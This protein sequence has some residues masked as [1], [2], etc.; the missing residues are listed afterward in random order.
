MLRPPHGGDIEIDACPLQPFFG[1]GLHVAVLQP[2]LG[3]QRLQALEVLIDRPRTDGTAA[4]QR[5]PRPAETGQKRPKHQYRGPHGLDQ[6]IGR[7]NRIDAGGVDPHAVALAIDACPQGFQQFCRGVD[8][9]QTG[10]VGNG[11]GTGCQ[12]G[13]YADRQRGVFGTADGHFALK[14]VAALDNQFVHGIGASFR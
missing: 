11:A 2:D 6:I 13:G 4:G 9:A 12:D 14:A 1:N 3:P 8:V 5:N 7:L 10:N